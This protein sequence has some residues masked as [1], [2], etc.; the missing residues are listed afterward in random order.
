MNTSKYVDRRS[1][2]RALRNPAVLDKL[3]SFEPARRE[4]EKKLSERNSVIEMLKKTMQ[5]FGEKQG[6]EEEQ[7]KLLEGELP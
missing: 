6:L 7:I 5:K 1:A 2:K 3:S 4:L